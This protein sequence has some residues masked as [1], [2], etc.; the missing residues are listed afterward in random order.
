MRPGASLYG[1]PIPRGQALRLAGLLSREGSRLHAAVCG[2]RREGKSDLLRQV[3]ARLFERGEGPVPIHYAFDSARSAESLARHFAASLCQQVRAFLMRQEEFLREPLPRL[4][5]ELE[6]PGLPLSLTELAREFLAL[7]AGD[8]PEAAAALAERLGEREGRPACL[9]FD[10]AEALASDS[11]FL[12][13]LERSAFSWLLSG[14]K[15][16]VA[17]MAGQHGWT[18]APLEPFSAEEALLLAERKCREYELRFSREAWENWL[19]YAGGSPGWIGFLVEA[20][21]VRGTS[22][23]SVAALGKLYAAELAAGGLGGWLAERWERAVPVFQDRPAMAERLIT[24]P[25]SNSGPTSSLPPAVWEGMAFEEWLEETPSGPIARVGQI[26]QDWLAFV[27]SVQGAASPQMVE[28]RILQAFLLRVQRAHA[29]RPLSEVAER[30]RGTILAQQPDGAGAERSALGSAGLGSICSVAVESTPTAQLFWCYG[31]RA[32]RSGWAPAAGLLL[33][34]LCGQ[35]PP[36]AEVKKWSQ[37]LREESGRLSETGAAESRSAGS[38]LRS[39][40]WLALPPGAPLAPVGEERRMRWETLLQLLGQEEGG[41]VASVESAPG[42]VAVAPLPSRL[43]AGE[44]EARA[45]WL[46]EELASLSEQLQRELRNAPKNPASRAKATKAGSAADRGE[47][48]WRTALTLG[49]LRMSSDLLAMQQHG[50]PSQLGA[51]REIQSQ[52]QKLLELLRALEEAKT[53]DPKQANKPPIPP[54][55]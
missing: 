8:Q 7:P 39:E 28:A 21:A 54:A 46:E 38:G 26:E 33:V 16:T 6:R 41:W 3:H 31:L 55:R 27:G 34:V 11:P 45:Q 48:N 32:G 14:R 30:V 12:P 13:A 5:Q 15:S 18:V 37:R 52:S 23:E 47:S 10:N 4:E 1:Q 35:E 40:L 2:G 51:L 42:A 24:L 9:L 50:N 49:L 20:A 44:L 25:R 53:E 19:N 22:L 36:A 17:H 29:S 43:P